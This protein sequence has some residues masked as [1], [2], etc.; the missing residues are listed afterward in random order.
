MLT[1]ILYYINWKLKWIFKNL[2]ALNLSGTCEGEPRILPP[3]VTM[4]LELT[5]FTECSVK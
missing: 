3:S 1:S 5:I 4:P 2:E